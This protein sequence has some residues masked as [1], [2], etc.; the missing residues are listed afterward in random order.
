MELTR[1]REAV[2]RSLYTRHGRK[3][4]ALCVCEG[5]R[6]CRELIESAPHLIEFIVCEKD[7]DGLDFEKEKI[8][9]CPP[10][11]FKKLA[12]TI[13]SQGVIAVARKPDI[14][15]VASELLDDFAVLLDK[16]SD[17][18]NFGTILRTA[19]AAGLQELFFTK[20]SVDPFN[21][22]V[23]R[24]ALAAQ[25]SMKLREFESLDIAVESLK[26]MGC[27]KIYRTDP[28]GGANCFLEKELFERS[29]IV[30]GGE[31]NGCGDIQDSIPLMIPMP[32]N[33]ESINVAQAATVILFE[34]VRRK[35]Q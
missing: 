35:Q 19:K 2:L 21:E 16:V 9:E 22:K 11:D 8:I 18:G 1:K 31:A 20:G 6:A 34:H 33:F 30:F 28:H 24:S 10:D 29:V 32:G 3:K 13:N 7:F 26:K 4:Y 5:L 23:I 14:G 27:G 25:F 15:A 17:P 12:V